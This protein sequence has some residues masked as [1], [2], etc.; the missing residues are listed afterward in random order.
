[1]S[2]WCGWTGC[3]GSEAAVVVVDQRSGAPEES[4]R[5]LYAGQQLGGSGILVVQRK[6]SLLAAPAAR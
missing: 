3:F 2:G 4:S 6:F 1:R 5:A